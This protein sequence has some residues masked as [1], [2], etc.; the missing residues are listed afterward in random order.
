MSVASQ[1]CPTV[2]AFD[3]GGVTGWSVMTVHPDALAVPRIRILAN[4][5][6]WEH[7]QIFCGGDTASQDAE[8]AGV[9]EMIEV[10]RRFPGAMHMI[11]KFTI[12][13]LN[14]SEEYSSPIRLTA[15]YD[16]AIRD[17]GITETF[18]QEPAD[19]L[20]E[21]D[22]DRLKRWG[23]YVR[24]GGLGHA[25]DADR[26]AILALRRAKDPKRGAAQRH[27]WWPHIYGVDGNTI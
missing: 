8:N 12:R 16:L 9:R 23:L 18:R 10:A 19:A 24:K 27:E 14:R 20:K 26:H 17:L 1:T 3:P 6:F 7:G 11:E 2:I 15:G 22:N 4:I 25:R 5:L 13:K 21:C